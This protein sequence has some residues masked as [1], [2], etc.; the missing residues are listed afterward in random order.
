MSEDEQAWSHTS[1]EQ[2]NKIPPALKEEGTVTASNAPG[3]PD[4]FITREDPVIKRKF[5]PLA[6]IMDY[7]CLDV[8]PLTWILMLSL[9]SM[10]HKRK[11][12]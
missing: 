12:G 3:I 5:T 4:A 6:R 10:G 2:L 9:L 8:I 7:L 11:Q 1:L